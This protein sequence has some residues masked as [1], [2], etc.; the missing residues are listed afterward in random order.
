MHVEMRRPRTVGRNRRSF[1][2]L[3]VEDDYR[4]ARTVEGAHSR[5]HLQS[6]RRYIPRFDSDGRRIGNFR[7]NTDALP[8]LAERVNR[9]PEHLVIPQRPGYELHLV[10]QRVA[11]PRDDTVNPAVDL[12]DRIGMVFL[13]GLRSN[14]VG[15]FDAL[16]L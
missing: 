6:Q 16:K 12:L 11:S 2:S 7:V 1:D 10:W 13:F 15:E 14:D 4:L 5:R 9:H 8:V 3:I